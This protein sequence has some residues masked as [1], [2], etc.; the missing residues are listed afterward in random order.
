MAK[1]V[2]VAFSV[3]RPKFPDIYKDVKLENLVT[4][5]TWFLFHVQG[6]EDREKHMWLSEN[7]STWN[8]DPNFKAIKSYVKKLT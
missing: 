7:I 1:P 6:M 3:G 2:P 5:D 4:E 8:E